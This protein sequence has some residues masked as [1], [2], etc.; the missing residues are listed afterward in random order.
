M[1]P[2]S[3]RTICPWSRACVLHLLFYFAHRKAGVSSASIPPR[4][5]HTHTRSR[6]STQLP[7]KI[8]CPK[9]IT[10][11]ISSP[12][13]HTHA[14][15]H[16]PATADGSLPLCLCLAPQRRRHPRDNSRK[17]PLLFAMPFLRVASS[18][19][20]PCASSLSPTS[21]ATHLP[22]LPPTHS[23]HSQSLLSRSPPSRGG[24]PQLPQCPLSCA[25]CSLDLLTALCCETHPCL[26]LVRIQQCK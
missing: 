15:H 21:R 25:F 6:D 11:P 8:P 12:H 10:I 18:A 26:S 19:L 1:H 14:L 9:R 7:K 23:F 22:P 5:K 24:S 20:R 16:K 2:L 13:P 17:P 4:C 3:R